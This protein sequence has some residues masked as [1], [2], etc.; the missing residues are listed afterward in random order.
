LPQSGG[1]IIVRA[2]EAPLRV[3]SYAFDAR[4][5]AARADDSNMRDLLRQLVAIRRDGKKR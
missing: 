4:R 5:A 3:P 2:G 1:L